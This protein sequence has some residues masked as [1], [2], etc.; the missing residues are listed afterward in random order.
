M[1]DVIGQGGTIALDVYWEAA[2]QLVNPVTPLVDIL[3]PSS[4]AV[5]TDAVPTNPSTGY[6]VYNYTVGIA[7]PLGTWTAHWTGVINGAPVSGDTT[8]TVVV[9]GEVLDTIRP[10]LG[11]LIERVRLAARDQP[12]RDTL[13]SPGLTNVATAV[14]FTTGTLVPVNSFIDFYDAT[15]ETALVVAKPFEATGV[16]ARGAYGTTASVHATGAP[17]LVR[18]RYH[19]VQYREAINNALAAIGTQFRR[20]RWQT[21]AS[22]SS[23]G[24][25][26]SVP[27]GTIAATVYERNGTDTSLSPI[28]AS[29]VGAPTSLVTSGRAL[30]LSGYNPGTGTAYVEYETAWTPL[31]AWTDT[32][33]AEYPAWAEDVIIEG[34]MRYLETPDIFA[35]LAFTKPH[36]LGSGAPAV[37]TGELMTAARLQMATFLQRRQELAASSPP[38][39]SWVKG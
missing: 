8:F 1:A 15:F 22:F 28:S 2:G 16:L 35:R 9:A 24:R 18:P 34:A 17:F 21:S 5:V 32:L 36:V 38:N 6:T 13:A 31:V 7:A 27:A 26:I 39:F 37:Q 3:N 10:T 20:K 11:N 25:L 4:V 23:S 14:N 19:L 33:D 12:A 29:L 30:S